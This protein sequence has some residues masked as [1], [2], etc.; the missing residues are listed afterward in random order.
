VSISVNN[1]VTLSHYQCQKLGHRLFELHP[2]AEDFLDVRLFPS[3]TFQPEEVAHFFFFVTSIDH[4]TSPTSQRF[5]GTVGGE[6]FQ[7]ADLLWHLSLR[8]FKEN[9]HRFHPTAMAQI[10]AKTVAKWYTVKYPKPVTIR[11]PE[12]RA[13][14]LRNSGHLLLHKYQGSVLNLLKAA[15]HRVTSDPQN[16]GSGLL[17]LLSQFKAY[18]DPAKKKSYLLLK[19]LL[20]RNLWSI[21]DTRHVRIP[22]DNHLTRIALRTGIV[23]VS[24]DLAFHLTQQ[25]PVSHKT[26]IFL[27]TK[28]GNAY[29]YVGKYAQQSVLELDDFFWHFGR[30][31]CLLT[32]P[33]CVTGCMADC[34]VVKHL[35]DSSCRGTCPLNSVCPAYSDAAQRALVEPHLET[36][37]Y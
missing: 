14:L 12:E 5:E 11:N 18:E 22:V 4:R 30:Q 7:G 16:P 3:P 31:C 23:K 21:T 29:S 33:V 24:S 8:Q 19:F 36:W 25:K 27:R 1:S 6:Y 13:A 10:G 34:F 20:R 17:Q 32:N 15:H 28:I 9:P 37:Y 35:L 26:D 2:K